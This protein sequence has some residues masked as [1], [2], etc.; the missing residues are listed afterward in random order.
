MDA[1]LAAALRYA[2]AGIAVMPLHAPTPAGCTCRD[3]AGCGS[4]G[5]H[6]RLRHGLLDAS[7]DAR[8]VRAWWARWPGANV[9]L[10]TGTVGVGAGGTSNARSA[11]GQSGSGFPGFRW[12]QGWVKV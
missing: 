9:G 4:P 6:P 10:V 3:G 12:T 11:G 2:A 8:L 5:K 1:L 7:T